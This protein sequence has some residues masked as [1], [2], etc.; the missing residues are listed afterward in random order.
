MDT[1]TSLYL[2]T[3]A[4][5]ASNHDYD[6]IE[7]KLHGLRADLVASIIAL[8][9]F[10]LILQGQT[11][12]LFLVNF[13]RVL[14]LLK[15]FPGYRVLQ[16]L[17]KY[18]VSLVRLLEIIISYYIVAHISAGVMLSVGLAKKPDVSDTWLKN[19]PMPLPADLPK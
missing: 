5:A 1:V 8:F 2:E 9:P 7:L 17:K 12:Y 18:N 6:A 3:Q 19:V 13:C 11:S 14:R 15:I 10:S 4:A 16:M